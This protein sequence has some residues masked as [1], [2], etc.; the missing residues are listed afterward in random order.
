MPSLFFLLL[1]LAMAGHSTATYC[2]CQDGASNQALQAAL[3]YAC[4]NGADC[5]AILQNGVCY[6]PN[7]VKDHCNYAV[8]SYFQNSGQITGSCNFSGSATVSPNPPTNIASTCSYPSSS[9][10]TGTGTTPPTGIP[11]TGP[12]TGTPPGTTTAFGPTGTTGINLPS[13]AVALFT[14]VN[15]IFFTFCIALWIVT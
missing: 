8:N 3:D 6:N 9:T 5:S 15:K 13:H 7:T 14:G 11:T 12:N 10:G 2:L 1:L 4:G